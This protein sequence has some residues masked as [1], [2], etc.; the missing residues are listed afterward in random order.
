MSPVVYSTVNTTLIFHNICLKW[1][2]EQN[3]DIVTQKVKHRKHQ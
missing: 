1:T 2:K 3:A